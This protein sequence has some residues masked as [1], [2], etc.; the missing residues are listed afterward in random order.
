VLLTLS[1]YLLKITH[2]SRLFIGLFYLLDLGILIAVRYITYRISRIIRKKGYH[3]KN[4]LIIGSRETAKEIIQPILAFSGEDGNWNVVGCLEV[5]EQDVGK[6]VIGEI[7]VIGTLDTLRDILVNQVVDEILITMPLNEIENSEW[8]LSFIKAF[9]ITTRIIPQW[10]I[11]KFMAT[12]PKYYLIQFERFLTEPALVLTTT[13]QKREALFIKSVFDYIFATFALLITLPLII[14]IACAIKISSKGP[15]FYRQIRCGLYGRKFKIY[16]FRTM[17]ERADEKLSELAALNEANGPVFKI[18]DDPRITPYVGKFLRKTNL[19]ELPQLINVLLGEMT[20][21]GPRPPIPAE[22]VQYELWQ[23]R[24][25]SMKPG[26]TCIWQIQPLRNEIPFDKW[27]ELDLQYIDHW[28]LWLDL[29]ILC[30]TIPAVLLGRG[31]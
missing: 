24:R 6:T 10:Y 19:D 27:M 13:S 15:V 11:R 22:V 30:K 26:I 21:V 3:I 2:I 25:L 17:I 16:K 20:L 7:K 29:K 12:R 4:I 31:R 1:M 8:Y 18:K 5:S 23:R 9:G 14:I 28:S